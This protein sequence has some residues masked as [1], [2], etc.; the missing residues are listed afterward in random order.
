[1]TCAVGAVAVGVVLFDGVAEPVGWP[2]AGL[3]PSPGSTSAGSMSSPTTTARA[4]V[5]L[6]P[7]TVTVR[8]SR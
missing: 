2:G 7:P 1:M 5:S 4:S 8:V 6:A 3:V